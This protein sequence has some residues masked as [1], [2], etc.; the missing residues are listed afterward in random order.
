MNAGSDLPQLA[1]KK[2][3]AEFGWPGGD[4]P[5]EIDFPYPVG[6]DLRKAIFAALPPAFSISDSAQ[7]SALTPPIGGIGRYR[8]S[9]QDT[10]WF[11]RVSARWGDPVVEQSITAFLQARGLAVNHLEHAGLPV[12]FEGE[13]LRLDVRKLVAGR[14]F[15]GSLDDLRSTATA[16]SDCHRML[17]EFPLREEVRVV[18]I[19]RFERL[20]QARKDLREA[21]EREDW[22]YFSDDEN[23]P[24]ANFAWLMNLARSFEPRFDL[25]PGAQCLHAQMHRGNVLMRATDAQPVF[26]D[27][28]EAIHT[29]APPAWDLAYFV[30]RFCFFDDPSPA[31]AVKRLSAIRAAYGPCGSGIAEMMRQTCWLSI[32]IIVS[33]R[34]RGMLNPTSEY[35]KFIRLERQARDLE[36]LLAR[37]LS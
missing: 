29:F 8:L 31:E 22:R 36:P 6:G 17:R 21:L 11:V 1:A 14:H 26:I 37:H 3:V 20:E 5:G 13:R 7:L 25:Q 18:S 9:D 4:H 28:E 33:R 32:A 23:W 34:Q 12:D 30:Q 35:D 19:A 16:L 2:K 24:R 15:D 27:F 10:A